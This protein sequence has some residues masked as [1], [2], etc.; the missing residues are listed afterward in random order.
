MVGW[1][2]FVSPRSKSLLLPGSVAALRLAV[3]C[4]VPSAPLMTLPVAALMV[5]ALTE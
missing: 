2:F 1:L 4:A 3:M 5:M